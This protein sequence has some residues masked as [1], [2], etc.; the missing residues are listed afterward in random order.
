MRSSR[1]PPTTWPASLS[2][3][4]GLLLRGEELLATAGITDANGAVRLRLY[5]QLFDSLNRLW[6]QAEA[7][8]QA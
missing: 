5:A 6:E 7:L 2:I 8:Q 1:T 3:I 4:P